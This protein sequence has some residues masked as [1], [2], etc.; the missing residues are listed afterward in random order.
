MYG[1]AF[2]DPN[3]LREMLN[4]H[5]AGWSFSELGRM[6]DVDHAS[7]MYQVRKYSRNPFPLDPITVEPP[8]PRQPYKRQ[9]QKVQPL[10]RLPKYHRILDEPINPGR[11]YKE[12]IAS[13]IRRGN[14]TI[15]NSTPNGRQLYARLNPETS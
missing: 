2:R 5:R 11:D 12:I 10:P 8:P 13:A 6:Y 4:K 1:T 15:I 14:K 3:R 7:I 9:A